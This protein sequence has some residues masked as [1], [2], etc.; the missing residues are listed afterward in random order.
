M[1]VST[2]AS[3]PTWQGRHVMPYPLLL[4]TQPA[5]RHVRGRLSCQL[6]V[7]P[8]L[9][10]PQSGR[11]QRSCALCVWE[12]GGQA[13]G[14]KCAEVTGSGRSA[15]ALLV[16]HPAVLLKLHPLTHVAEEAGHHHLSQ[17][18]LAFGEAGGHCRQYQTIGRL[19][20][21]RCMLTAFAGEQHS[22]PT[23]PATHMH[24]SPGRTLWGR[25]RCRTGSQQPA[26]SH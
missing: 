5:A 1:G 24:L 17:Q 13:G 26:G 16:G 6:Q 8:V 23:T 18:G 19:G 22:L 7:A 11:P 2:D 10:V 3:L 12:G 21:E 9:S 20:V 25:G 14:S 15:Q 4:L